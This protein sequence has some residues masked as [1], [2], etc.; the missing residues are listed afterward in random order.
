MN[1]EEHPFSEQ[2]GWRESWIL[3]TLLLLFSS[4]GVIRAVE[5]DT[6]RTFSNPVFKGA[7]PWVY[8]TDSCYYYC[9]VYKKDLRFRRQRNY[10]KRATCRSLEG[11][12]RRMEQEL[13]L[14][15]R[16]ALCVWKVV[17]LLC[18]R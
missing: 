14:G 5:G 10:I 17:H 2:A 13:Y 9:F 18:G 1:N 11:S 12:G 3:F 8:K 6:V 16:T 4:S 7:D 15:S